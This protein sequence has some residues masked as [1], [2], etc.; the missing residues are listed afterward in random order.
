MP[1]CL[2]QFC[3]RS[4]SKCYKPAQHTTTGWRTYKDSTTIQVA[5]CPSIPISAGSS[6][7]HSFYPVSRRS[8]QRGIQNPA[9][10]RSKPY[11]RCKHM[12]AQRARV[13]TVLYCTILYT[14]Y[15]RGNARSFVAC[16]NYTVLYTIL[17]NRG[18]ARSF[19]AQRIQC[20]CIHVYVIM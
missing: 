4:D 17:S 19:V 20:T 5:D 18:N 3:F 15:N 6:R 11:D 16:V 13:Y 7:F 2:R 10:S 12:R 14:V 1:L 8:P 9:F